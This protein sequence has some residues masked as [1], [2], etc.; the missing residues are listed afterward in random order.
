VDGFALTHQKDARATSFVVSREKA[1][2]RR[3]G[4]GQGI[5]K[6]RGVIGYPSRA[7]AEKG[8]MV[9]NHLGH[10]AGKLITLLTD[11]QT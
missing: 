10:A 1:R 2:V 4:V 11:R 9:L 8:Q 3:V 6:T 7:D 5:R